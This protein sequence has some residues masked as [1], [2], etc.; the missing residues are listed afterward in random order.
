MK[1]NTILEEDVIRSEWE[2]PSGGSWSKQRHRN[3]ESDFGSH[4]ADWFSDRCGEIVN[5]K[6]KLLLWREDYVRELVCEESEGRVF[7]VR[8]SRQRSAVY[9]VMSGT[10]IK[11]LQEQQ[12]GK[13]TGQKDEI[14]I[15]IL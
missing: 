8:N 15:G 3:A 6:F 9:D 14:R 12:D 11:R 4:L 13:T 1:S 2:G 7:A 5:H 10:R